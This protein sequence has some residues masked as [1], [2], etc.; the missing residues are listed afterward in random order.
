[1][2]VGRNAAYNLAGFGIPLVLF[3]VTIPIYIG[4][5]GPARY[6]VL[7]IV[8]LVLGLGGLLDL[9]LGRAA[10]Q[11]VAS[12]KNDTAESRRAALGTA[13]ATNVLIGAVGAL[14]IGGVAYYVFAH[15]MK[16]PDELRTEA[17]PL[18]SFM[19]LSLPIVTTIGIL[20]GALMGREKFF[21]V[22]RIT[23]IN[24]A[25]FQ[26]LPLAIAHFV[27]P[28]L[29]PLVVAALCA[30]VA[31]LFLLLRECRREFGRGALLLWERVQFVSMLKYGGWVS[32]TGL[33]GLMLV[34]SDRLLIGTVLGAVAVTIYAVPLDATRRIAVLADSLANALFPRLALANKEESREF[35]AYAVGALYAITTPLVAGFIVVAEPVMRIWLGDDIGG[36]SA[37]LAQILAIAGWANVFAKVPYARLQA[38]NRP[39]RVAQIMLAELPLYIL[40]LWFAL[41]WFGPA[42]AA[43]VYLA[44]TAG[45]TVTMFLVADGRLQNGAALLATFMVLLGMTIGL[46][47][48]KPLGAL[49]AFALAV[50][51]TLVTLVA[52]WTMT[53]PPMRAWLKGL[54]TQIRSGKEKGA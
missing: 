2:S 13:L 22:N 8:W 34:F 36:Q 47:V 1:M 49:T 3:I 35:S 24:G 33:I 9:G 18:V 50:P 54:A 14:I 10:N 38:Q 12:L 52:S 21:V 26:L 51:V 41:G 32:A 25:L 43:W 19:A 20:S 11:R 28:E 39:H 42:G 17:V 23:I 44:R 45:D 16:M 29:M 30:R 40:A 46:G 27:G 53:P 7:A 31:A 37:P 6:G 48:S 15:A 5:I 4:L